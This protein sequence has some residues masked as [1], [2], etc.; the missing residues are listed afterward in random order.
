MLEQ[1]T[2]RGVDQAEQ[3]AARMREEIARSSSSPGLTAR[4]EGEAVVLEG[5][6]IAR[7]F[8]VEPS[9]RWRLMEVRHGD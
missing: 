8:A 6:G 4:V 5:R 1:L 7:R 2:A 9:L 3:R